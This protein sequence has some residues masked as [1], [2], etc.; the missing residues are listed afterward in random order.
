MNQSKLIKIFLISALI[1]GGIFL[2]V[3]SV[4]SSVTTQ[5]ID[6]T[7]ELGENGWKAI[8]GNPPEC[9]SPLQLESPVDLSKVTSILY[10]G[11][12]RGNDY[13]A[14]GGFRFDTSK[15]N[16]VEV[17]APL[18]AKI[19]SGSRYIENGEV[20]Y[21]FTFLNDCGIMYRFD[22][23]RELSPKL[24]VLAEKLP[25]AKQDDS[26]TTDFSPAISVKSGELLAVKVG[27]LSNNNTSLDFG[28][29]D[30]REKNR[31]AHDERWA[32]SHD[33]LAQHGVCWFDLLNSNNESIIRKLPAADQSSGSKSDF[34]Q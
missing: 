23:L 2:V 8:H 11:Q 22:H 20:Q 19:I 5:S 7:W 16:E 25:A 14:H 34:C 31:A 17:S 9:K 26:R 33:E 13:K 28:V 12:I 32:S 6:I 15:T 27:F 24:Q 4:T 18:E 1:I 3:N 29:Y 30:L 21:L 10:P